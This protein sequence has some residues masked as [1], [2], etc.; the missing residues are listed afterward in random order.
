MRVSGSLL[1]G[2]SDSEGLGTGWRVPAAWRS[3][4]GTQGGIHRRVRTA[5][6]APR[7]GARRCAMASARAGALQC[8]SP[9][10]HGAHHSGSAHTGCLDVRTSHRP[11]APEWSPP[12]AT[13]EPTP[14]RCAS[15][16]APLP[17]GGSSRWTPLSG[18]H[19]ARRVGGGAHRVHSPD[20]AAAQ[21]RGAPRRP[22]TGVLP[23][24]APDRPRLRRRVQRRPQPAGV[25][26]VLQALPLFRREFYQD[27][28]GH[29]LLLVHGGGPRTLAAPCC[30][31]GR[32]VGYMPAAGAVASGCVP[33]GGHGRGPAP[34]P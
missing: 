20:V 24:A 2:R 19:I 5:S 17:S 15:R 11:G 9:P 12:D 25:G 6:R 16:W 7:C 28:V 8:R 18:L 3:G 30:L 32:D 23:G 14:T 21:A 4:G 13:V 29:G 31:R 33:P 26:Q 1:C 27:Q 34:W 10:P 22:A